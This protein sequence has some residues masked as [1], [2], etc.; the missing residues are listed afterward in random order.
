MASPMFGIEREHA[1][2]ERLKAK[3]RDLI[4]KAKRAHEQMPVALGTI[5]G[6]GVPGGIPYYM[7]G[8]E[9]PIFLTYGGSAQN[10]VPPSNYGNGP[11]A[12]PGH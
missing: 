12:N 3:W 2:L 5:P 8:G 6:G 7:L 10:G 4:A 9:L 1:R 11:G